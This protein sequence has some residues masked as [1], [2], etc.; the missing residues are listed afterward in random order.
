MC[1]LRRGYYVVFLLDPFGHIE[2]EVLQLR[3][4][5]T[6]QGQKQEKG[7]LGAGTIEREDMFSHFGHEWTSL[8]APD[9]IG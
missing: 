8:R 5:K 7:V 3:I 4:Y 2:L 9:K 1:P 6:D